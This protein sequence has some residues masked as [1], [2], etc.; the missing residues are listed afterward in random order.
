MGCAIFCRRREGTYYTPRIEL[1]DLGFDPYFPDGSWCHNEN[2]QDY[3]CIH[4]HCLPE[5]YAPVYILIVR[6]YYLIF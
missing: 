6:V 4:H 1:N 3:Y 2:G 5:V